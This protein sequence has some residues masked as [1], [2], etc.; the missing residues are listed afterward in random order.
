[1][2][3]D[4]VNQ[5]S[6][7]FIIGRPR[8][9]T[10]LL[11]TLFDAHPNVIIP[12]ECQ[13]IKLIYEKHGKKRSWSETEL[14][15]LLE[16]IKKEWKFDTWNIDEEKLEKELLGYAGKTSLKKLIR[17]IYLNYISHFEKK[18]ILLIGDK[19]PEYALYIDKL[20]RYYPEAKYIHITRDYRDQIL[21][22]MKFDFTY[23]LISLTAYRWKRSVKKV[24]KAEKKLP[25]SFY[26]IRYE[27]L[28]EN[29]E[30]YVKK[31]CDFL[32]IEYFPSVLDF[33]KNAQNTNI[34]VS[35]EKY[36]QKYHKDLFRP[37]DKSSV[38]VWKD[39]MKKEDVKVADMIV[40][41]YAE[42]FGY[43]RR[44]KRFSLSIYL[45]ILPL[46][47]TR[48]ISLILNIFI[49]RLPYNLKMKIKNRKSLFLP[50]KH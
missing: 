25:G 22:Y 39:K 14:K 27:D 13:V 7:F 16:D 48:R 15:N 5:I 36:K 41:K 43:E 38:G 19:N 45:K 29:P 2:D 49:D 40:G 3:K 4:A 28:V 8:S 42:K 33:H 21:S 10:T 31:M 47:I 9:G 30:K 12:L 46:L 1:M 44:S 20:V 26:T 50:Q 6:F 35:Q 32:G 17:V 37:I 34:T 23:P 18:E 11:R 24:I